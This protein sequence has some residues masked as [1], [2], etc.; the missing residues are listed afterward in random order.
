MSRASLRRGLP[1]RW[2][3]TDTGTL[4]LA[5]LTCGIVA[6]GLGGAYAGWWGR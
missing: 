2:W 5:V 3:V 6:L 4:T 1:Y